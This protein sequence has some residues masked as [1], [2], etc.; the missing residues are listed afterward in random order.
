MMKT[1]PLAILFAMTALAGCG[2][3]GGGGSRMT[4]V[5]AL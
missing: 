1:A 5:S 4:R 3:G 2:G